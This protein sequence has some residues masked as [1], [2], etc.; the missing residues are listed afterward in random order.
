MSRAF[1][2]E[3]AA[4]PESD[5]L[6]AYRAAELPL[7]AKNYTTPGGLARLKEELRRL[8]EGERPAAAAQVAHAAATSQTL[9]LAGLKRR[10]REIDWRIEYL[11]QRIAHAEVV[12]AARRKATD[13][14]FFGAT[15]TFSG[16]KTGRRTV[17]IVGVEEADPA[18]GTISFVS[19]LAKALLRAREGDAVVFQKPDAEPEELEIV[20]V[21]YGVNA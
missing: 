20:E 4:A 9:E 3:N 8:V 11:E 1:I 15:V 13:Q 2:N 14:V 19:P 16:Q 5:P 17:T 12:D 7:T 6:P 10:L 18:N 21:R